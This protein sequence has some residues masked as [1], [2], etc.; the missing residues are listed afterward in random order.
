MKKQR[1]HKLAKS[2]ITETERDAKK[3]RSMEKTRYL[4]F[5]EMENLNLLPLAPET[6]NQPLM[7]WATYQEEKTPR[8]EWHK[9]FIE[10]NCN[11]A[12]IC[13]KTSENL[14]IVDCDEPKLAF[15][16]FGNDIADRTFVVETGGDPKGRNQVYFKTDYPVQGEK[17]HD[18]R[19]EILGQGNYA[20]YPSSIHPVTG[21]KYEALKMTPIAHIEGDFLEELFEMLTQALGKKFE[22][23]KHRKTIIIDTLLQGVKHGERDEAAVKMA[24]WLRQGGAKQEEAEAFMLEWNQK[25]YDIIDNKKISDPLEET[26]ILDKIRRAYTRHEPY[27]YKFDRIYVPETTFP[28]EIMEKAEKILKEGNPFEAINTA[29]SLLHAGD[30]TLIRIEWLS[31]L[32]SRLAPKIKVN[33]WQI[34]KSQ[35][36][37][38]HSL[39]ST[40]HVIPK[41]YYEIFT[42]SSPLSF[43][44][45]VKKFGEW[46]LDKKLIFIDEV[47]VSKDALPMLRTL[48]GQTD[49]TPRHLSVHEAEVLDLKIKGKRSV[50]FTSVQTFGNE[51]IK[52]RFIHTNPDETSEQ[53]Q[54]VFNLQNQEYWENT[55]T[56]QEPILTAQAISQR[57]VK[58]TEKL[59]VK[60]PFK[61]LWPFK[62]R[63]WLFPIFTTFVDTIAKVRYKQREI[64]DGSIIAR[65]EDV[66]MAKQLWQTFKG[67]IIYRVSQS[68]LTIYELLPSQVEQALTHTE[69]A[70]QVGL[71]T[72]QVERLC[73]ELVEEGLINSRKRH[74]P[75]KGGKGMWEYWKAKPP[76]FNTV[77]VSL[78][79]Y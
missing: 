54:R 66:E 28:K 78:E 8:Q 29:V 6:K 59:K 62:Q 5:A 12:V 4:Q 31:A 9:W 70:E 65:S 32:S 2:S 75:E 24:S 13:G 38:S 30:E 58:D 19:I 68:A 35:T 20:V 73:K 3:T 48:T 47:E 64:Q 22:P 60:K 1:L 74:D 45:Y 23:I 40:L 25:N 52:N 46:S 44:Y 69:I 18:I 42:S 53:D 77:G 39:Y 34:G 51:Q 43:F 7:K 16:I 15:K 27:A 33:I 61:P 56:E 71:S 63:R 41:E 79:Q 76:D 36:G 17:F 67:S 49:I 55:E 14:V 37:K 72:R 11:I 26:L 57:I 50:W 10:G 21:R